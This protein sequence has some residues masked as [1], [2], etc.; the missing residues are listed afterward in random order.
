MAESLPS[1]TSK[2]GLQWRRILAP[3]DFSSPSEAA[4]VYAL[5]LASAL[6]AEVTA[7]HVIPVPHMLDVFYE[8]GLAPPETVKRISQKARK[9]LK[10]IVQ[11]E[12]SNVPVRVRFQEGDAPDLIV[13]H[14][15]RSKADLIV[16]GTHGRQ[17]ASRF[18]LGSVAEAIV[19]R[20]PC[21]VLTVRG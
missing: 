14:A 11:A 12:Q 18:F 17:G 19:R 15:T 9:R 2:T 1:S 13:E 6:G 3:I 8:R 4:F 5:R 10:E 20:A 7:Y 16:M 21:P